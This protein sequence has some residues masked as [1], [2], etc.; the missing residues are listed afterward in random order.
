MKNRTTSFLIVACMSSLLLL[1]ACGGG[2]G[3][4][5]SSGTG[6]YS[7]L[8]TPVVLTEDNARE[9]LE[10]AY[11]GG[12]AGSGMASPFSAIEAEGLSAIKTATLSHMALLIKDI[13]EKVN[14]QTIALISPCSSAV[15]TEPISDVG[16]CGGTLSGSIQVDD[17]AGSLAGSLRFNNYCEMGTITNGSVS[18]SGEM[19]L[20]TGDITMTMTFANVSEVIEDEGMNIVMSGTVSVEATDSSM[21]MGM[22]IFMRDN[23]AGKSY[24]MEDYTFTIVEYDYISEVELSGRFY[25]SDYGYVTLS[26]EEAILVS[27]YDDYPIQGVFVADGAGSSSARLTFESSITYRIEVDEDGDGIYEYNSGILYWDE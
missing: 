6:S 18:F 1:F 20:D 21:S 13:A 26:T 12:L 11:Y 15:Q 16:E 9:I 3:G 8:T 7:G 4:S 17:D 25:C 10:D 2:G 27:E 14:G 22:D 5:G 24:L 19:D 23:A